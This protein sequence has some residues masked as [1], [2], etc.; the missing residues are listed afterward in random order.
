MKEKLVILGISV[1]LALLGYLTM[2]LL[3]GYATKAEVQN[4]KGEI[5]VIQT[6]VKWIRG[7]LSK[8]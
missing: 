7:H 3:G 6:D 5:R 2:N 8:P 4:L 1:F